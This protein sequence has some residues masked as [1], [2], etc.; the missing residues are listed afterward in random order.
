M[1][2]DENMMIL[3]DLNTNLTYSVFLVLYSTT[4]KTTTAPPQGHY[5]VLS[6]NMVVTHATPS[7]L[8]FHRIQSLVNNKHIYRN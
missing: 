7:C 3:R 5:D 4:P 2:S 1:N 6:H 8:A